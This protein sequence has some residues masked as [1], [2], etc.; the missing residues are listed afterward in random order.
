MEIENLG[1][2]T[3]NWELVICYSLFVIS[4]FDSHH[5]MLDAA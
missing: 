5:T 2:V 1:F 3:G 4:D